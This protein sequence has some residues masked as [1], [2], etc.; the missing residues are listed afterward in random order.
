M[1]PIERR[2]LSS[3]SLNIDFADKAP[4]KG[5]HIVGNVI[6]VAIETSIVKNLGITGN[7]FFEEEVVEDGILLRIIKN[8]FK[9]A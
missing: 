1:T 2:N 6:L 4:I 8:E 5:V 9:S 3:T 7:T